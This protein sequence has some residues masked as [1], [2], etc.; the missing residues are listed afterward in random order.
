MSPPL[1][2]AALGAPPSRVTHAVGCLSAEV[3]HTSSV[4]A[5][6]RTRHLVGPAEGILV[7][8]G[9]VRIGMLPNAANVK[10]IQL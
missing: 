6:L 2:H 3:G 8:T 9:I 5:T 4:Q 7:R 1:T 10:V